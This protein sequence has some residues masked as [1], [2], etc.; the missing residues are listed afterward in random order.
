MVM[1]MI[2]HRYL[3]YHGD[4][5]SLHTKGCR[6][7]KVLVCWAKNDYSVLIWSGNAVT[8]S[9]MDCLK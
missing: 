5:T 2:G 7:S 3:S 4:P 8:G 1:A 9:C 6:R